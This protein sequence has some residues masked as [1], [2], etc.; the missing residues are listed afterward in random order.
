MPSL[1]GSLLVSRPEMADPNFDGTLTLLLE[2]D[3]EG[4]IGVIV[5]RPGPVP[6]ADTFPDW[7]EL[8]GSP[9]VIFSGGPVEQDGLVALGWGPDL[10]GDL[11]LGLISVDLSE[12]VPF[13][14]ASGVDRVR[15]FAG[16]A[17]WGGG[18][19]EGELANGAWW[20]VPGA[21]DDVFCVEPTR[22]WSTV[23]RRNGGELAWYAHFPRD[24]SLN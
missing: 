3:A 23:L 17:G 5:N 11:G 22:L 2:H 7:V 21:I 19:L 14:M 12:Q 20:V 6:V 1:A 15:L 9:P 10:V 13:V 18:Q 16:Y 8:S 24:P 4:A